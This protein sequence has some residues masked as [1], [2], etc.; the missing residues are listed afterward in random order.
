MTTIL[1]DAKLGVMAADSN[2]QT[3]DRCWSTRKVFRVRGAL[4]ATAGLSVQGNAFMDWYRAGCPEEPTFE[5]DESQAL[6]LDSRGL[7]RFDCNSPKLER[8]A[9]GREAI[10]SGGVAAIAAYEAMGWKNP[11]KAVSIACKHDPG[12]RPPVRLYRVSQ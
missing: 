10:G 7:W 12:S 9:G 1:A 4:V 8:V 6:V 2:E 11:K 5:F 3:D